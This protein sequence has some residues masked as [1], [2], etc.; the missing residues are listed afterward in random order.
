MQYILANANDISPS[1]FQP[2][3]DDTPPAT[4]ELVT[5]TSELSAEIMKHY[6]QCSD[7]SQNN[8]SLQSLDNYESHLSS[9]V[10]HIAKNKEV[11]C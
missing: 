3:H 10:T 6:I 2:M 4:L 8:S 5:K 11:S 9:E 1:E 7:T